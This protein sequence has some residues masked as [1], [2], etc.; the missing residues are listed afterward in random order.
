MAAHGRSEADQLV[1]RLALHAQ[2]GE[3]TGNLRVT[4]TANEN[5]LHRGF[6]FDAR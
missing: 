3:E 2:R 4:R 1:D 5:L 6:S